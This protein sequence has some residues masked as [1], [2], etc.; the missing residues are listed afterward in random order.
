LRRWEQAEL[1]AVEIS[2]RG[3]HFLVCTVR[4]ILDWHRGFKPMTQ[5]S[6]PC[7][8]SV[9]LPILC[10]PCQSMAQTTTSGAL[11]GVVTDQTNA[12]I[13][14]A[15][16]ELRDVAKGTMR[17]TRTDSEG[18]Y[19]FFFLAP[20]K[21]TLH[22]THDGFRQERRTVDVL[23]GPPVTV[24]VGLTI[25]TATNEVRVTD[26]APRINAE[27]GDV[28]GTIN[29][30]QV[31]E[32]PN[33]GNDLTN[34]VQ[35]APGALMNTDNN[36]SYPFS[37]LGMPGGSYYYTI[38]G[39]SDTNNWGNSQQVGSLDLTL[40]QNQIQ[41]ATV[42]T[43][44]YSGQ[45]GGAAGGNI[46]Y[47]TK[48]GSDEFHGN[49]QYFWNGSVL[50]ANNYF[51]KAAG[52]ARPF[53]IANQWAG[54]L[55]GPIRKNKLFFF[56]NH[57]GLRIV[58]P[59]V[60]V[61]QVPSP[62][63]E[64]A[65]IANIESKFGVGSASDKFYHQVFNLYD[66]A[67]RSTPPLPGNFTDPLAC[68]GFQDPNDPNGPG[69]G[70]VPCAVHF[71]SV[72]GRPSQEVL[73]S[74]R[75]DWNISTADRVFLRLQ[76][77]TGHSAISVDSISPVFDVEARIPWWQGQIVE[78]HSFGS[79][80]ASQFLV[81]SSSYI[82]SY[83]MNNP[84]QA[85]AAL[86][87]SIQFGLQAQFNNLGQGGYLNP[88]GTVN[89]S[90]HT[91]LSED[92]MKTWR[93]HKFGF[94][95][96]LELINWHVFVY[97]PE[98]IGI[99]FP[100][101]LDAFFQGGVDPNSPNT[102]FTLLWQSF[103]AALSQRMAFHNFALYGQDEWHA[104]KNLSFTLGIRAEHQSNPTC[105]QACFARA[106]GPFQSVSHDPSEPYNQAIVLSHQAFPSIDNILW[107]PRFSF[108]WQPFGV[109]QGSVLR[110]GVGIF[111]DSN[112][113]FLVYTFSVEPPLVNTYIV[114]GDN[115][116]P[117]ETTSLFK[118][119]ADSN[120]AFVNGFKAGQTLA[121]I[122]AAVSSVNA[123]GFSP[124]AMS[125]PDGVAHAP[126]FQKWSLEWQ[127]AFGVHSLINVGY[128]GHH[129]IHGL[130]TDANAN[131]WGFGLL[132]PGLC[133]TPEV[134]PCADP[135]FSEVSAIAWDSISNYHG[136]VT[137]F[138]HRFSRWTSG[139]FQLN[140]TLGHAL[141]EVSNGGVLPFTGA[142][143]IFPQD[144]RHLRRGYGP[145]E[146]DVRHSLNAN[147]VWELPL[148]S[149]FHGHAP[150]LLTTGWE[151]AGTVF[152]R[153]GFPY[154]VFD[155]VK[156]GQLFQQNLFGPVYAVP[157]GP[158]GPDPS[159]GKGAGFTNPVHPCQMPQVLPGGVTPNPQ[160]RFV[161]AGCES[162]FDAGNLGSACDGPAVAFAQ[163]RNRFRGPG[164]FNSDFTILKN[165]KLPGWEKASLTLGFQF[166]NVFNHPNFGLPSNDIADPQF[167][168]I[169]GQ[170]APFA[171]LQGNNTGADNAR[172][173]IQLKAQLQF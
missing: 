114:T 158:L 139:V 109:S 99:L 32:L 50:N 153:S 52:G 120:T 63:M 19:Q 146:Y 122:Q 13:P 18:L 33:Q 68:L 83:K 89:E 112:P 65:T 39:M 92:L 119:A 131:A 78:T 95:A 86:P 121:Q 172:R 45:F 53:D 129:G 108:A 165:T 124:P 24:N 168:E 47:L 163:G 130:V 15:E 173:L 4:G 105:E 80:A 58:L 142:S 111:Y 72:R 166:F 144:A 81:A 98:V 110:G 11:T 42:V 155:S 66:A 96:N 150:A 76:Y 67:L 160:A 135:R 51:L 46:N 73:T 40:G 151:V 8:L 82:E 10:L 94:G 71:L 12:V 31:S 77:D 37:I 140:Y 49:A 23:L 54:S 3:E 56:L 34:I 143:N 154:S 159:C 93:R 85:L 152:A 101:T 147:Y 88:L 102:D 75:L 103:P 41:E 106:P 145:A 125:T 26:E 127:Q 17:S 138:Q 167:G 43:T 100:Q 117:G 126:Q 2:V 128:F 57:E 137:S 161:Q 69:H 9:F 157:I 116:A 38:D 27:N 162:G 164:Y 107:S 169:F 61:M 7:L 6:L 21:Y 84:T 36:F 132:S 70:N 136:I 5:K 170:A 123:A 20:S 79:S 30:K 104:R 14:N 16:V 74:G 64:T 90:R 115:L 25:A 171:N 28:S 118:D 148:K 60:F 141:D 113:G 134:P 29:Q 62:Q 91:Q 133:T 1:S 149:I 35:L 55:G 156:M 97:S 87:T 48:S 22:V 59:Q 44:G